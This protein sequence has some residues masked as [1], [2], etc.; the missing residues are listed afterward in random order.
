MKISGPQI[1]ICGLTKPDQAKKCA[2]LGADAIGMVFYEK[3]PRNISIKRAGEI[4]SLLPEDIAKVGVFVNESFDFVMERVEKCNLTAVQLHGN[5]SDGFVARLKK[6]GIF[7]IK[8]LFASKEPGMDKAGI[9]DASAFLVE[10]GKGALPGGNARAWDWKSARKL[11]LSSKIPVI[12]AGG[13]CPENVAK[14]AFQSFADA[15]DVSSGVESSPGHKDYG[16]VEKFIK[17]LKNTKFTKNY[18]RIF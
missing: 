1:K 5:E 3:S 6:Q 18:R 12:I 9:Y 8:A 14:A 17:N 4:S 2:F 10:C 7:V 15:V 11:A 13:L 16:L